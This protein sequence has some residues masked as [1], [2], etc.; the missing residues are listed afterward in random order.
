MQENEIYVTQSEAARQAGLARRKKEY[1][2]QYI[3][4][5]IQRRSSEIRT[6][7]DERGKLLV[8][9]EDIISL[10]VLSPGRRRIDKDI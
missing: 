7:L 2:R 6:K 3:G 4:R 8:C 1:K 10:P 9:L 5:L